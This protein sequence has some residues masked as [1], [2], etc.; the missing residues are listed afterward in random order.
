[1]AAQNPELDRCKR[2]SRPVSMQWVGVRG[3][4]YGGTAE[5]AHIAARVDGSNQAMLAA[6]D[7]MELAGATD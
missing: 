5:D 2:P 3:S 7:Q 6:M 4:L 1:M